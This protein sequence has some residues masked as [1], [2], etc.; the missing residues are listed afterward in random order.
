MQI[1]IEKEL[2]SDLLQILPTNQKW[3]I[4]YE[5]TDN[6]LLKPIRIGTI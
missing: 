5:T 2:T 6:Q 1:G 3:L 4:V